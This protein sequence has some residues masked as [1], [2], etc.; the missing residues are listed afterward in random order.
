MK[1]KALLVGSILWTVIFCCNAF[2][3]NPEGFEDILILENYST[4]ADAFQTALDNLGLVYTNANNG[5]DWPDDDNDFASELDSN[6]DGVYDGR[7]D[8]VIFNYNNASGSAVLD[9]L[10]DFVENGGHLIMCYLLPVNLS[11]HPLWGNMGFS[12]LPGP[13]LVDPINFEA[14]DSLHELFTTPNSVVSQ[15]N[16]SGDVY[17]FYG[18]YLDVFDQAT[19]I[20]NIPGDANK[21]IIVMNE[22]ERTIYTSLNTISFL[23]DDNN[24][25]KLDIVELA[26]NEISYLVPAQLAPVSEISG[27][28]TEVKLYPN[29]TT[30]QLLIGD[31]SKN[32][33]QVEI[34]NL[35][36]E[37]VLSTNKVEIDLGQFSKGVYFVKV[38]DNN[39]VS[40]QKVTLIR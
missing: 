36:G 3:E 20:A 29:P 40:T 2:A 17:P 25:G 31:G 30:G 18:H 19:Q 10:N 21:G 23:Q 8:L 6:G 11:S 9:P 34:Y 35:R 7:W 12:L 15:F 39:S 22:Q 27:S 38:T 13:P 5:L 14:T 37:L 28:L 4:G 33:K 16:F 24:D 32:I 26:E 1:T